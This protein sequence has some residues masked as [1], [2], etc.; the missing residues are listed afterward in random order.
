MK[1][2]DF[3]VSSWEE[4][5]RFY[6]TCLLP[7]TG[8]TGMENPPDTAGALERLRDFMDLVEKPFQGRIVTYPALQYSGE[9]CIG[10][11]ND[12]CRKVKSSGFQYTVVLT[13][14]MDVT[15]QQIAESDLVLSLPNLDAAQQSMI[16]ALV[17]GKIQEMWQRGK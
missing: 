5:R 1:F 4:N 6:D 9:G 3:D 12:I 2:S 14:D 10:L 13:A 11:I 15:E 16:S 7:L 8:L 17:R